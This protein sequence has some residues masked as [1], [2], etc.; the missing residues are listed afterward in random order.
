MD[1]TI[2]TNHLNTTTIGILFVIT[3]LIYVLF[4]SS[5]KVGHHHNK[6]KEPPMV[7]GAWPILGHLPLLLRGSISSQPV[8]TAFAAIADEY[9]PLFAM[10][11]GSRKMVVLSNS[12]IAKECFTKNDSFVSSRP[13]FVSPEILGYNGAMFSFMPYGSYWRELRK[14]MNLELLSNQRV[15]QLSHVRVSEVQA[16]MK[17]LLNFWSTQKNESG[18][19]FLDIKQWFKELIFNMV[20]RM[21]VGKRVFGTMDLESE[22]KAKKCLKVF[23]DYMH[24]L[25]EFTVGDA[26]PF[27][28]W[29]DLG[30]REKVMREV[31][32]EM[33]KILSEW[34]DDHRKKMDYEDGKEATSYE[35]DFI[36]VMLSSLSHGKI[37]AFDADTICKA[38]T[39]SVIVGAID[40]S[41]T[42][43]TWAMCLLLRNPGVLGK[44]KEELDK[45][46]GKERCINESDINKLVYIQAIVKETLRLYPPVPLSV[47]EFAENT[48]LG[49][50][51]IERGTILFTNIW[52]INTDSSVWSDCLEFQPEKFLT[53]HKDVDFRG[54]HFDLLPFGSGRRICPGISFGVQII[55]FILASFL[56]SF[57][58]S[59]MED[60]DMTG[61][62]VGTYE[63]ATPLKVY[64]P[65]FQ[66]LVNL[67]E[68][69]FDLFGAKT[70]TYIQ[71]GPLRQ[72]LKH[73]DELTME[74]HRAA[75]NRLP[76]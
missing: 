40:T 27:L 53:T 59:S 26:I 37:D 69:K 35:R 70:N 8:H 23:T 22:V 4:F 16:S 46:I 36:D 63:K 13:I 39:L 68:A 3:T 65:P 75:L 67:L 30:G 48:N 6:H 1:S 15:E 28:R 60:V 32:K 25:E 66:A 71:G 72:E 19:V 73:R 2:L 54:Q 49:G 50:Y 7:D 55:H 47:R 52:K 56:H 62:Q 58:I 61:T 76:W 5:F 29:L 18:Y 17:E 51:D 9:G 43:L 44:A 21:I 41:P 38:T 34:L 24:A 45:K 64:P 10:K 42:A 31:S 20:L 14:I 11:L 74:S 33:D 12:E 57:E